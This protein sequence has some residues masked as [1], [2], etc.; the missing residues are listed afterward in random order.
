MEVNFQ[1]WF[2]TI[3]TVERPKPTES[4]GINDLDFEFMDSP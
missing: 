3:R 1:I 2:M 4:T